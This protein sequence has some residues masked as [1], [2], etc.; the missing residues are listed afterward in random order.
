MCVLFV[1]GGK[2]FSD[3]TQIIV[4]ETGLNR[5]WCLTLFSVFRVIVRDQER[6]TSL[7]DKSRIF[8]KKVTTYIVDDGAEWV[9]WFG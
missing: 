9:T 8:F 1:V 3:E 5:M 4:S 2:Y 7:I 6:F